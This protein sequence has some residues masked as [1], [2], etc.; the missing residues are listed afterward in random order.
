MIKRTFKFICCL[1]V[2]SLFFYCNN[3]DN[4]CRIIT[5]INMV[6]M[7]QINLPGFHLFGEG[8]LE[9]LTIYNYDTVDNSA[10]LIIQVGI[11]QSEQDAQ[12]AANE[13]VDNSSAYLQEGPH[14][15]ISIGN[16]FWWHT[17]GED[18]NTLLALVFTRK[19]VMFVLDAPKFKNAKTLAVTI[20]NDTLN[21][22]S[23][24]TCIN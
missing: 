18:L 9:E 12:D 8:E 11:Y 13:F 3:S 4:Y 6:E 17:S 23:Y 24:I 15:G 14:Q 19:N 16:N 5:E 10:L 20:D 22:A 7:G 21:K 1:A 2:F